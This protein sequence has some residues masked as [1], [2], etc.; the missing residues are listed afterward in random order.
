MF[1]EYCGEDLLQAGEVLIYQGG[2]YCDEECL[3]DDVK[4]ETS[5]A[6][7]DDVRGDQ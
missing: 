4:S 1:C 7:V 6:Y 2:Y 3:W 5:T